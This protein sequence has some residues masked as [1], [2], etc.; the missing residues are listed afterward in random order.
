MT[1][2]FL[3]RL[4]LS[5]EII[6]RLRAIRFAGIK[7]RSSE[8]ELKLLKPHLTGDPFVDVGASVGIY[9]AWALRCRALEVTAVEPIPEQA[10]RL[11]RIFGRAVRVV[12]A[13][14]SS[15]CGTATLLIPVT[16][17]TTRFARASLLESPCKSARR[18][19]VR[20]LT[21]DSLNIGRNAIV[22]IDVEGAEREVLRGAAGALR[23]RIVKMWLIECEVRHPES[24]PEAL[25]SLLQEHGYTGWGV[26]PGRLVSV[27]RFDP[28]LH[29][30]Q[31]VADKILEGSSRPPGYMNNFVFVR[32]ELKTAFVAQAARSG[33]PEQC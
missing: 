12:E 15:H 2:G 23:E 6:R 17:G 18:V 1:L 22:K 11:T 29:Q 33:F 25:A 27:T 20:L 31:E 26:L 10:A 19:Q 3:D 5:P 7:A 30:A 24:S 16:E 21:L 14:L 9:T 28:L 13:A 32:N 4:T 8:F